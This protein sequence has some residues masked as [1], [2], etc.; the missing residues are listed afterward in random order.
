MNE[1]QTITFKNGIKTVKIY[2]DNEYKKLKHIAK[3]GEFGPHS[4]KSPAVINYFLS[5]KIKDKGFWLNGLQHNINGPAIISYDKS[6]NITWK[7]YWIEHQQLYNINS[8]KELKQ[9]LKINN[10]S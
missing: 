4:E 8:N 6:G 7:E 10:I 5:G 9:Y 3:I 2:Y 1:Y